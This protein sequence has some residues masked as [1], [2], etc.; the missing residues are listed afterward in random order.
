MWVKRS[1][2][3]AMYN[4]WFCFNVFSFGIKVQVCQTCVK[5][6]THQ[7]YLSDEI[8]AMKAGLG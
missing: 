3:M 6:C 2:D 4:M 7:D 1:V 8:R 5:P